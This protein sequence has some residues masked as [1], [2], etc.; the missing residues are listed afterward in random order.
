MGTLRAAGAEPGWSSL[1]D[2][3]DEGDSGALGWFSN[4]SDSDHISGTDAEV[5]LEVEGFMGAAY[6]GRMR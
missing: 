4:D 2:I 5:S 6:L 1:I 3:P